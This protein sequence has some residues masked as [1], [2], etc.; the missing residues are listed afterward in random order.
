MHQ[1]QPTEV[2]GLP[3]I[4]KPGF[5]L[6]VVVS[7]IGSPMYNVAKFLH[8]NLNTSKNF[9]IYDQKRANRDVIKTIFL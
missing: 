3:K 2:Y 7:S 8:D 6:R 9:E 5:S 4:H 1:W